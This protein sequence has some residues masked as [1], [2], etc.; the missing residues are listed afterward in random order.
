MHLELVQALRC[1]AA[2]EPSWLVARTD[3]LEARHI[4]AGML[5]C[6]VCGAEYPISAGVLHLAPPLRTEQAEDDAGGDAAIRAAALLD[7]TTP[8]GIVLLAGSWARHAVEVAAL[9]EG[10]HVIALDAP[11]ES[12]PAGMG[13]SRIDAGAR[14]PLGAGLAR[15][16]AIDEAHATD[17]S[18]A[19]VS[20]ALA[21]GGRLIA[22]ADT[23]L[24]DQMTALAG[25]ARWWVAE[26]VMRT[27]AVPLTMA[28]PR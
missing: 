21:S 16:I 20:D 13:V 19:E 14:I 1:P 7:L 24:P 2:H 9:T 23:P 4:I 18:L 8:N 3:Q 28:P 26:R 17:Q 6:P 27:R 25:D 11:G 15:G 22:P 5:G 10:I 12:P